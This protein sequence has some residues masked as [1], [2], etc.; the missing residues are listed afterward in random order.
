[1]MAITGSMTAPL[2]LKRASASRSS[3]QWQDEDYDVLADGKVVGRILEEGSRSGPPELLWQW[4]ITAI[5]PASPG[6]ARHRRQTRRSDVE[7]S[8]DLDEVQW[9]GDGGAP[10]AEGAANVR[11]RFRNSSKPDV[12][13]KL[14][15]AGHS[16][17]L[18]SSKSSRAAGAIARNCI[19]SMSG[20]P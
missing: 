17:R 16:P 18:R 7:V 3:G 10:E 11:K 1:V 13:S 19:T 9:R 15:A 5:V 14:R 12:G 6:D 8:R 20:G 2:V 4:S